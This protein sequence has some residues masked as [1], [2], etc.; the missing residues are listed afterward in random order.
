MSQSGSVDEEVWGQL[1]R[2]F[3]TLIISKIH[4]MQIAVREIQCSFVYAMESKE[5]VSSLDTNNNRQF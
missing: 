1:P 4:S 3:S 2:M 5:P